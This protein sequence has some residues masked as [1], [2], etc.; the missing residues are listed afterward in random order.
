MSLI[1]I[2]GFIVLLLLITTLIV[3][4]FKKG[5]ERKQFIKMKAASATFL[6]VILYLILEIFSVIYHMT[7]THKKYEMM[8]PLVTLITFCILYFV[9]LFFFKRKY[10]Y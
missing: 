7:I 2:I 8:N 4:L 6:V 5:D 10:G 9:A 3:Y 1:L